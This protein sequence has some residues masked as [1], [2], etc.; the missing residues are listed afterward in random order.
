VAGVAIWIWFIPQLA[1]LAYWMS[2]AQEGLSGS[3][4]LAADTPRQIAN[5]HTFFN[6]VNAFIFIGFTSQIARLAEW[7]I[8]DR[9]VS[10]RRAG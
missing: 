9:P 4:K 8:P 3:A 2:P 1:E 5:V 6:I 10:F 7:L